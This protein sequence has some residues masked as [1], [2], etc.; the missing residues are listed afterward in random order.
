VTDEGPTEP[1]ANDS[2]APVPNPDDPIRAP[3]PA[4]PAPTPPP[5]RAGP[6]GSSTFTIEG[7]E[8]PA[9][10]VIGWLAFLL[11]LAIAIA[12][13][14]GRSVLLGG[15]VGPGL[16]SIGLIAACGNQAF[17]RRA[18]GAPYAGP[19]PFLVFA[20]AIAVTVFISF[21][22]GLILEAGLGGGS[23]AYAP[24]AQLLSA[25]ITAAAFIGVIRLTVVGTDALSWADMQI[26]PFSRQDVTDVAVGAALA[27]P[28]IIATSIV[29]VILLA[30]FQVTPESPL[31][32]T[33]TT[34]GLVIQLIVGAV[35]A[36]VS[37]EIMFRGFSVTAWERAIGSNRAIVRAS[38][39]FA[40]AHVVGL[41]VPGDSSMFEVVGLVVTAA[42]TR[43]PVALVLGWLFVRR[44]SI[45]APIALH[46]TFNAL[47]LILAHLA[48]TAG[49]T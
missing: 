44:R 42:V 18:R 31:P 16:V 33:G 20:T 30:I 24:L 45:W 35:I 7:R 43:L 28:V 22:L 25:L 1:R 15:L 46:A 34:T 21:V 9:L 19:S 47:L 37:E 29:A 27:G 32:P 17:E 48:I 38:L 4:D 8:S 41:Q 39:L 14:F 40:L 11:G 3:T 5:A 10:F 49:G 6:P 26:R 2:L 13:V 36:P 12:G 23:D